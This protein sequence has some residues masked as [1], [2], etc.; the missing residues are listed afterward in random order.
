MFYIYCIKNIITYNIIEQNRD[1]YTLREKGQKQLE[2]ENGRSEEIHPS[3]KET[4]K[5]VFFINQFVI[6]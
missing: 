4:F 1:G 3:F 2:S 6:S 5:I